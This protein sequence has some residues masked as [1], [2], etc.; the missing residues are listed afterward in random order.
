MPPQLSTILELDRCPH[1]SVDRP[2]LAVFLQNQQTTDHLN[3]NKRVWS[4][5]ACSR[6]GGMVLAAA[7]GQNQP[8]IEYY[9]KD[10]EVD[11]AIPEKARIY[12]KQAY[13]SLHAP[14]GAVM[15]AASS[16]DAMLKE[17]GFRK[18]SLYERIEQAVKDHLITKEMGEWAHKV[19]LDAN[20]QRHADE[21]ATLPDEN[22]AKRSIEFAS[23]LGQFMFVL[24]A[25][26]QRGLKGKDP[27]EE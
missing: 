5:Y 14:A 4:T 16:V 15:L 1:C 23:A 13:D 25:L 2:R 18:G 11:T 6:C 7:D 10:R 21:E 8:V 9:P 20:D 3:R 27:V 17:K 26:V 24:P 22:D 19:R 12:L